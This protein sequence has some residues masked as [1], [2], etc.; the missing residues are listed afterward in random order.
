MVGFLCLNMLN[1]A[2]YLTFTVRK[3]AIGNT[4]AVVFYPHYVPTGLRETRGLFVFYPPH[5]PTGL[6]EIPG[7]LFSTHLASLQ[8]SWKQRLR[9]FLLPTSH[10][11]G[12]S[13][14]TGF[15]VFYPPRVP[16]GLL[17]TTAP[18]FSTTY[19]ASLRDFG[20]YRVCCFLPTSR[21]YRTPGNNGSGVFYYLHRIP[22]GLWKTP[23]PVFFLPVLIP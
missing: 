13:G 1:Y 15:V 17:E 8:D 22:T 2:L 10:P 7:L 11:Y 23:G 4:G 9:C 14:N 19:I 20:K 6:R 12:T 16:T 21:P 5:V 18:V 3:C